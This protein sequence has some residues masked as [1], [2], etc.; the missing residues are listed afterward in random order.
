SRKSRASSFGR[1]PSVRANSRVRAA[2]I[3]AHAGAREVAWRGLEPPRLDARD[4]GHDRR[5]AALEVLIAEQSLA[6]LLQARGLAHAEDDL[7]DRAPH[8]FLRVPQ[9][10]EPRLEAKRVAVIVEAEAAGHVVER[11]LHVVKLRPE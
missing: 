4:R 6:V 1:L 11:E 7:A 2:G 5:A 8:P 10:Q 9:R 3:P